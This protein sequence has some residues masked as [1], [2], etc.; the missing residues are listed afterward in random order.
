[1]AKKPSFLFNQA[2]ALPYLVDGDRTEIV[3][4]TSRNSW[5]W[6]LQKG[7]I[8][9]G[10]TPE[11][12]GVKEAL[13]EAGVIGDIA[14]ETIGSYQQ[15][16]W[17]GVATISIFPLSV[18]E[19]REDW[20]ERGTRERVVVTLEEAVARVAPRIVPIVTAFGSDIRRYVHRD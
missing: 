7:V 3:L 18:R 8:D 1:M 9:P 13:E 20:D 6:I 4:I 15:E 16:K 14:G 12:T 10:E 19:I 2:G 17:G 5:D 11:S